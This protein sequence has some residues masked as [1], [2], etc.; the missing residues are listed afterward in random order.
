[1]KDAADIRFDF[2]LVLEKNLRSG[3]GLTAGQLSKALRRAEKAA[4]AVARRHAG[5]EIG[6]P[7]LPFLESEARR[8]SRDAARL[9]RRFTHMLVLG[10]GGSALGAKAVLE[11]I[12]GS[13]ARKGLA[14]A[15]ADNVDP[16]AFFP[17][18]RSHPMKTTVVVAIS[19]SGGTAETNA[20][21]ALAADALKK[22][23]G[24]SWK[25]H[26]ILVTD[27]EKGSFRRM[28]Q[29]EGLVSYPVPP[30]VGGRYSV[31]SAVGLLPLAAAG[32]SIEKLLLGAR[33]MEDRFRGKEP[34]GNPVLFASA[35][36]A[37][38]LLADPKAVQVWM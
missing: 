33:W 2:S 1:M 8:I 29:A 21:L 14:L 15:V 13:G 16:D 37:H 17:L 3:D 6:F 26:L 34:E 24:R 22:A 4:L 25:D 27:P 5:G 9:R 30:N 36:Y 10:I 23:N 38:Y 19:K 7:D 20:Q 11:G 35:V 12:G 18:L 32:V 31:L 28:A